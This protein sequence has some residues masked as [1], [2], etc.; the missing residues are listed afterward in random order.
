MKRQH[1]VLILV[2]LLLGALVTVPLQATDDESLVVEWRLAPATDR[3]HPTEWLG[4][5][6]LFHDLSV[7]T[8]ELEYRHSRRRDDLDSGDWEPIELS[9]G[10]KLKVDFGIAGEAGTNRVARKATKVKVS[11]YGSRTAWLGWVDPSGSEYDDPYKT[12]PEFPADLQ[13][14]DVLLFPIRLTGMPRLLGVERTG[15]LLRTDRVNLY[16][17]CGSCGSNDTPCTTRR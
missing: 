1:T 4:A 15:S 9:R 8:C 14:G 16:V 6:P 17:V 13:A 10:G 11:Q 2:G 5:I 7:V 12:T 3:D